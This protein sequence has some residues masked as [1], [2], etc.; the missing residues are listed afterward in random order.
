M[1]ELSHWLGELGLA[2]AWVEPMAHIAAV[3]IAIV[4]AWMANFVA[5]KIIV[6]AVEVVIR[7]SS[8]DWD[9]LFLEHKVFNR[10]SQIAPAL[11]IE[12]YAKLVLAEVD[13]LRHTI[14]GAAR[15]YMIVVAVRVFFSMFDVAQATYGRFEVARSVPIR[16][17]VQ[18]LKI[19]VFLVA[20]ILVLSVTLHEPPF[21]FLS[22]LGAMTAVIL[23]VFKDTILG[24]VGGIHLSAND[25]VRPGDWIEMPEFGADG[26]VLDVSLTTVKVQNWDKTISTIPTYALVSNS[27]KNW[28]GMSD[29]GG[30]RIK[31]SIV[32][33]MATVRFLEPDEISRLSRI[34]RLS[35]YIERKRSELDE[36][37]VGIDLDVPANGRRLTNV[38]CFRAYLG[39]FLRAH[40]L[41]RKDMTFL[42]RQLPPTAT[43][44]PIEIY[45]FSGEQRWAH[46]EDLQSD[47]FDHIL[48]VLGEFDL[49][50]FQEPA[51][52]DLRALS[53]RSDASAAV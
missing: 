48:A 41:I 17:I 21:F 28:R 24:F 23:L 53:P 35:E 2:H 26:D 6:R 12:L 36:A 16:G 19:V 44:L 13:W 52:A 40:P 3:V 42:V 25:M 33:D 14:E 47:I 8:T 27:F 43:G 51:G 20:A 37:N 50:V 18:A 46:Y 22:G 38:G 5:K 9:D 45:V 32:L 49:R 7:R 30:R 1:D 34:S 15:I 4:A 11:V 39:E 10:L 31:R 29:S